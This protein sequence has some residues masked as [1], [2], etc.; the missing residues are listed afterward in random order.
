M[1]PAVARTGQGERC[2]SASP[3]GGAHRSGPHLRDK[4]GGTRRDGASTQG[5]Q[6]CCKRQE[7]RPCSCDIDESHRPQGAGVELE[8]ERGQHRYI[9]RAPA[10]NVLCRLSHS[11]ALHVHFH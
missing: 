6:E 11:S 1:P 2:G 4:T 5:E 8:H 7:S 9:P 3:R 10:L